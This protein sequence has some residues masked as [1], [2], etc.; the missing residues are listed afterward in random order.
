[1]IVC[2]VGN[3]DHCKTR[4]ETCK[5]Y[6]QKDMQ[7]KSKVLIIIREQLV[8]TYHMLHTIVP[9]GIRS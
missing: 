9:K 2:T 8:I 1:M 3:T 4:E 6:K 7:E 5:L